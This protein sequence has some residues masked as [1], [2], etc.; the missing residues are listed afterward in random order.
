MNGVLMRMVARLRNQVRNI[1]DSDDAVEQY[2]HN[3]KQYSKCKVVQERIVNHDPAS[4][5][6]K[7]W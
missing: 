4:I 6:A 5:I 1:V 3:E 2:D 7:R